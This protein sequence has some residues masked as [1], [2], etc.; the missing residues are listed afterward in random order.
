MKSGVD[1]ELMKSLGLGDFY[2]AMQPI[3]SS[4]S[5]HSNIAWRGRSL[6]SGAVYCLTCSDEEHAS[7]LLSNFSENVDKIAFYPV[8]D[9]VI[10]EG[11][12]VEYYAEHMGVASELMQAH[13]EHGAC[14]FVFAPGAG[15]R[16]DV[17]LQGHGRLSAALERLR[18]IMYGLKASG[19]VA[20]VLDVDMHEGKSD[21][22]NV[23]ARGT[24]KK[25]K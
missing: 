11:V 15:L 3:N 12:D 9:W 14:L 6:L 5:S 13:S 7:E 18:L 2:A 22:R 17:T 8:N 1:P 20:V 24:E 19:C 4:V 16:S 10:G 21:A 25:L 23:I